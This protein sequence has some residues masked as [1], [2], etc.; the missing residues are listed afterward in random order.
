MLTCYWDFARNLAGF[1]MVTGLLTFE[2]ERRRRGDDQLQIEMLPGPR[3]GFRG[4]NLWPAKTADRVALREKVMLPM[5]AMLPTCSRVT[6]HHEDGYP[7]PPNAFGY[8]QQLMRMARFLSA[9]SDS[10]RPLRPSFDLPPNEQLITITLREAEHWPIRNSRV[11]DWRASA[12]VL[13]I[14]GFEVV[15]V[16]DTHKA[17][18][19][20]GG[21]TTCPQASRDLLARAQ[22]YRQAACNLFVSNGP[23]WFALALDAPVLMF[24]PATDGAGKLAS[25]AAMADAG[26]SKGAQLPNGPE[27]QRL[28]WEDDSADRIVFE[29]LTFMAQRGAHRGARLTNGKGRNGG[30]GVHPAL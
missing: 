12:L 4:D 25:H 17:D 29:A 26:L 19:P 14:A 21:V 7:Q 2:Q 6:V 5:C 16:R 8:G 22:L 9:Y 30:D 11:E 28:I 20:L 18:E 23:A 13:T 1:D 24:R 10:I 3:D 27:H 15:V